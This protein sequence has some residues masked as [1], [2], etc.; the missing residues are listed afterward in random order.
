MM[1]LRDGFDNGKAKAAAV[2]SFKLHK[3]LRCAGDQA[4]YL[5]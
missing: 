4:K 5:P 2:P 3:A 1:R